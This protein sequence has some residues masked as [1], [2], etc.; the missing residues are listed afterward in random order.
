M[1]DYQLLFNIAIAIAAFFGGWTLNNITKSIDR[2]DHDVRALPHNYVSRDD[3]K[4]D[5]RELKDMV[6]EIFNR[7]DAK[8][9]RERA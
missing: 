6:R 2:L 3:Y 4:A 1:M 9:D 7:L 5:I 8:A